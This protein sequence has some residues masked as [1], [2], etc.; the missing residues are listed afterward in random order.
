MRSLSLKVTWNLYI[1]R[2]TFSSVPVSGGELYAG[3][4]VVN[5]VTVC[6]RRTFS[7]YD[8]SLMSASLRGITG[9]CC[10]TD[11]ISSDLITRTGRPAVLKHLHAVVAEYAR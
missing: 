8:P 10:T 7:I 5:A 11:H 9:W 3:L 6:W 4:V 1:H 2:L